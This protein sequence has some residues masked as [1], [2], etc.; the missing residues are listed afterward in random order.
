M[1]VAE[2][3]PSQRYLQ[4]ILLI[5]AIW[6]VTIVVY[7]QVGTC[8]F[9][10]L[11]DSVYVNENYTIQTGFSLD[12][13][14]WALTTNTDG[15]WFPLTWLS[16]TLDVA[17]CDASARTI[18]LSNLV[19]HLLNC[20]LLL[21]SL[22]LLTGHVLRS[23]F[24]AVLFAVHPLHVE[25][26]AWVS[27]RKDLLST[28]FLLLTIIAY[29]KYRRHHHFVS[30]LVAVVLFAGGLMSKPMLVSLPLL[31]LC[32][33][34]WPLHAFDTIWSKIFVRL[35]VEKIPFFIL[36]VLSCIITYN[37]QKHRAVVNFVESPLQVNLKNAI[38]S[39]AMYLYK[40]FIPTR[41]AVMYPFNPDISLALL[42]ISVA[43]LVVVSGVIWKFHKECPYLLV[44]W[45]WYGVSLV[46][47][48]GIIRVG[49]QAM[50]DRYTYIPHIGLFV[51]LVWGIAELR[52]VATMGHKIKMVLVAGIVVILGGIT[53]K[54][55][56]YWR[57]SITLFTHTLE[58]TDNNWM[59]M[60]VLGFNYVTANE[61]DKALYYFNK[62]LALNPND[63]MSLYNMGILQNK[64]GNWQ[65]A[66]EQF[67]KV[68]AIDPEY[69]QAY[70]QL[71]M[72]MLFSGDTAGA[73]HQHE[74]L[75]EVSSELAAQ[76][77]S[78]ILIKNK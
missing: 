32:L 74:M 38:V 22:Y 23:A 56:S 8:G 24:V 52:C 35:C 27:E 60:G 16:Y 41:L 7:S 47:V 33:D 2:M 48:I 40:T 77:M 69:G 12:T 51:L 76:L 34:Y 3:H 46:P 64:L 57:T 55:V 67:Q 1:A 58:V 15:N 43:L 20:S 50:A 6:V 42:L 36:S 45:V 14:R 13:F 53:W 65:N 30:Y 72:Q 78:Q 63:V 44:G 31:L 37:V 62:A 9:I 66:R 21:L 73:L 4:L 39:Y 26:V 19:Y 18:H 5:C 49:K 61:L 54:Q 59:A 10:S 25:S 75:R 70:Y 11:D 29:T 28:M 68:I 17:L 71:G